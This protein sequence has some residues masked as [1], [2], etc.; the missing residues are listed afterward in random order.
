M[1][2]GDEFVTWCE[3]HG[4]EPPKSEFIDLLNECGDDVARALIEKHGDRDGQDMEPQDSP[5]K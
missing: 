1:G 5:G 3:E 2:L 4:K